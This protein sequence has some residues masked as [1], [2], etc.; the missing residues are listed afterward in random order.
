MFGGAKFPPVPPGAINTMGP[1]GGMGAMGGMP[2]GVG[3]PAAQ[4]FVRPN[5]LPHPQPL[6]PT[7]P[8]PAPAQGKE[9]WAHDQGTMPYNLLLTVLM[10]WIL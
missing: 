2:M 9:Q 7:A 3:F 1:M 5:L 4:G 8:T 10:G 6:L